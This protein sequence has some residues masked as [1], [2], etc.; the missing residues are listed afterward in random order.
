[1]LIISIRFGWTLNLT[2]MDGILGAA[3]T[4]LMLLPCIRQRYS[5]QSQTD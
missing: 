5:V 1:M 4:L 2:G 3:V